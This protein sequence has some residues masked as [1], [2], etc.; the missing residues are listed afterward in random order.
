MGTARTGTELQAPN[1]AVAGTC[2]LVLEDLRTRMH[3]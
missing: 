1:H 3:F 2:C